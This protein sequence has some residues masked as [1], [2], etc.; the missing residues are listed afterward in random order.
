MEKEGEGWVRRGAVAGRY[1]CEAV[2]SH[3]QHTE[4]VGC[5]HQHHSSILA[6]LLSVKPAYRKKIPQAGQWDKGF[7]FLMILRNFSFR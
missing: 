5:W 2:P 6:A 3:A 1:P 4:L 7:L